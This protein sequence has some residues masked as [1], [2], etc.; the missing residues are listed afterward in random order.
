MAYKMTQNQ[1]LIDNFIASG[2]IVADVNYRLDQKPETVY[3]SI[4]RS[5]KLF[6]KHLTVKVEKRENRVFLVN[7]VKYKRWKEKQDGLG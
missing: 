6:N 5:I 4:N 1:E 7:I 2:Y 3:N